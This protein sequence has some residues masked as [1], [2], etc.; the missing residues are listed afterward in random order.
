MMTALLCA[1]QPMSGNGMGTMMG[2][3][4]NS[5]SG[6]PRCTCM[7][8]MQAMMGSPMMTTVWI[9]TALIV[10]ASIAALVSLSVFLIRRS[11]TPVVR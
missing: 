7:R 4:G 8:D 10:I 2:S 6:M 9:L 5:G 11:H 3:G 1:L